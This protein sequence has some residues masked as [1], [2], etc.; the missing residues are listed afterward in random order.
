MDLLNKAPEKELFV[1]GKFES[2]S[3]IQALN[4]KLHLDFSEAVTA[5]EAA[6]FIKIEVDG[7]PL[8]YRQGFEFIENDNSP[9]KNIVILPVGDRHE[10]SYKITVKE[11][12]RDAGNNFQLKKDFAVNFQVKDIFTISKIE[13]F[14]EGKRHWISINFSAP[15]ANIPGY[16]RYRYNNEMANFIRNSIKFFP[17]T[18]IAHTNIDSNNSVDVH[19]DFIQ[20]QNYKVLVGENFKSTDGRKYV[21]GTNSFI[22]PDYLPSIKYSDAGSIIERDSRQML[23]VKI[24]NVN[25]ILYEGLKIP[26]ILIPTVINLKDQLKYEKLSANLDKQSAGIKSSL[27]SDEDKIFAD[28]LDE[29][30][31]TSK[32]FFNNKPRNVEH[33]FSIPLEFRD[34]KEKGS[35]ELVRLN[36]NN[37]TLPA[38]TQLNLL[39]ISDIGITYKESD[40][41]L[42]V[43]ITSLRTGKPLKDISVL[44]ATKQLN[45]FAAGRTDKDGVVFIKNDNKLYR[46]FSLNSQ[47]SE[48]AP[49]NLKELDMILVKG[50]DDYSYLQIDRNKNLKI[51]GF[52]HRRF[53]DLGN[54]KFYKGHVFTERGMYQPGETVYFKGTIREYKEGEVFVPG[55]AK[56]RVQILSSKGEE[57]FSRDFDINEFGTLKDE[58]FL[59]S[60]FPL[61][62]YTIN[63]YSQD[64]TLVAVRTFEVQEFKPP[65]H[66]VD[67]SYVKKSEKDKRFVNM[68]KTQE[69]LECVIM[70]K[71]YA[72]G[73]VK[74]GQVRWKVNLVKTNFNR[75]DYPDFTF[76]YTGINDELLE[77]GESILNEKGEITL[78]IPLSKEVLSGM[79]GVE[80]NAAV[81]DFDAKVSTNTSVYQISPEYLIGI[82]EH[83]GR[84]KSKDG[85]ILKTILIDGKGKRIKK[86]GLKVDVL[87]ENHRYIRKRNESGNTYWVSKIVW[88]REYS[89]FINIADGEAIFDFDFNWGGKYLLSFSYE[90]DGKIYT[91]STIYEVEGYYYYDYSEEETS[92]NAV[93]EKVNLIPEKKYYTE[94]EDIKIMVNSKKKL[95]TYLMT[96]E[97]GD[98]LDYKLV[99]V[100]PGSPEIKVPV[101]EDYYPNVYISLTGM[102]PRGD[103]PNYSYQYDEEMPSVAFGYVNVEVKKQYNKIKVAINEKDRE[104]KALPGSEVELNIKVLDEKNKGFVS[105]LAV[106]VVDESVLALTRY[107]TPRLN[108]LIR[109]VYPLSVFTYDFTPFLLG[110]TPF[111]ELSNLPLTGG[112]GGDE[113]IEVSTPIMRKDFRPVAYFNPAV[114]TDENG[115]AS[116]RFKCPDTITSYRVYVVAC[117]KG[118]R[119]ES[120]ERKLLVT[121]DFYLEPGLPRF[122]TKGDTFLFL[123]SAF[124]KTEGSGTVNI[125][126]RPD[127]NLAL[128]AADE[129]SNYPL[130]SYDRSLIP[131][132]GKAEKAGFSTVTFS[133]SFD[134]KSDAVEV[135]VPVNSGYIRGK[136]VL[137]GNFSGS[138]EIIYTFPEGTESIK[139]RDLNEDEIK[140]V[141]TVSGSPFFKLSPGLKYLLRYPYGCIEQ[142]SSGVF[143]LAALRNL[144]LQGLVPD[145]SAEE[146]DKFLKAGVERILSMQ[147]DSGGFGYWPGDRR[148]SPWGSIYAVNALTRARLG[149][150]DVPSSLFDKSLNYLRSEINGTNSD[151]SFKILASYLLAL[152]GR[153][154]K[155]TFE[156]VSK[157]K[158]REPKEN[159]IILIAAAGASSFVPKETLQNELLDVLNSPAGYSEYYGHYYSR[160]I[161]RAL[162]LIACVNIVSDNE[163]K[164]YLALELIGNIDKQGI[165][166]T[167]TD[168]GWALAALG[169]YFKGLNFASG[170]VNFGV[171]NPQGKEWKFQFDPLKN[172]SLELDPRDFMDNPSFTLFSDSRESLM[173]KVEINFPRVDYGEKGYSNGFR[174]SK[175]IES[176]S[177]KNKIRV[178][179]IVKVKIKIE[180][181]GHYQYIAIDDPFPA[182]FVAINSAIKTEEPVPAGSNY[183][184]EEYYWYYWNPGGFY[185]FVPNYF[186]I[187]N[188]RV[189]VFKN[190]IWQGPYEYSYY[191]R[192]VCAGEFI[193]PSSKV[194]LMYSPEIVA[195][196]P[197]DKIIIE[198]K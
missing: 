42:L 151:S 58:I 51:E 56:F 78:K 178:G 130:N 110:Q 94:N 185:N 62:T 47:K 172:Y 95:S 41:S 101:K 54:K 10:G 129:K 2:S 11:G 196:T 15:F 66:F 67:V 127:G 88:D 184:K 34:G 119:F 174:I 63:L 118:S 93:Y 73:P 99:Q 72:G 22:I 113:G 85:Q 142:T 102:V 100:S 128:S 120:V 137:F 36:N 24:M 4:W 183:N 195:Y 86:A 159:R 27:K 3:E 30:K 170:L 197:L 106:G 171:K 12:L 180:A 82:S 146:T 123:L 148:P 109:F 149:G 9:R 167:T 157:D 59:K 91:S 182:G 134:G 8:K 154:D 96:V 153:L 14:S 5:P 23:N 79:A 133:G 125:D 188:D 168:T 111:S 90:N 147:T 114:L 35:V 46:T 144:I 166:R 141:L 70:G 32:L 60:F 186:E 50:G 45:I 13:T 131:V 7:I 165:W 40:N 155:N 162:A 53:T 158:E 25:E 124:N 145:I 156:T 71:Y 16:N 191:A 112:G 107:G 75:D 89:S 49:L 39:S 140:C 52:D 190:D 194:E 143:P 193:V 19:G 65:R 20:G 169:E 187:R 115:N 126:L 122:L 1:S 28:F 164:N 57:I 87:R 189:L 152:N 33:D 84:I 175:D 173:Y 18:M 29:T 103:F 177:G 80:I 31:Y 136:D 198:G 61:G 77:T 48:N 108:D 192:A 37:K 68:E 161:G 116:I 163:I 21:E 64:K 81:L 97:R 104:L 26:P 76:G 43:W 38:Q 6:E 83:P 74:N 135:K 92:R 69:Y 44:L 150:F 98:I 105:E 55:E 139:W 138:K 179:D 160:H 132:K 181:G 117:D 121:R 17:H 176:T